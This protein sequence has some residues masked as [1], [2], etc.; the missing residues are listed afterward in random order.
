MSRADP[1]ATHL[2]HRYSHGYG[3]DA[4]D[5]DH[6]R[7]DRVHAEAWEDVDIANPGNL[8]VS[9]DDLVGT[10]SKVVVAGC[11]NRRKKEHED[12]KGQKQHPAR[13]GGDQQRI[14]NIS[15]SRADG[16]AG[17][18]PRPSPLH[19]TPVPSRGR[20]TACPLRCIAAPPCVYGAQA[21][22]CCN[23]STSDLLL[24][25]FTAAVAPLEHPLPGTYLSN[26]E[27]S[28]RLFLTEGRA[29]C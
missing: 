19:P 16:P 23:Q 9:G 7:E 18:P 11:P 22:Q 25:W 10:V 12:A 17:L 21:H 13:E 3:A 4:L 6:H 2:Q 15:T 8:E 27:V 1:R 24:R 29:E 28:A 20:R 14:V 5:G 26:C